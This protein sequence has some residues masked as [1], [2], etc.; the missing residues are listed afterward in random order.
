MMVAIIMIMI[1]MRMVVVVIIIII[2]SINNYYNSID[3]HSCSL[4][5]KNQRVMGELSTQLEDFAPLPPNNCKISVCLCQKR[6]K[7]DSLVQRQMFTFGYKRGVNTFHL[8]EILVNYIRPK[9][10]LI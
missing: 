9:I 1:M 6:K 8:I 7:I 3:Y 5:D 10:H 2:I 4:A